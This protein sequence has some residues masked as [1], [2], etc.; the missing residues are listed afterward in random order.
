MEYHKT[1]FYLKYFNF[2]SEK[3]VANKNAAGFFTF[4]SVPVTA[5]SGRLPPNLFSLSAMPY[6]S[7]MRYSAFYY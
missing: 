2:T 4:I 3:P 5:T 7:Q 1:Y 6:P